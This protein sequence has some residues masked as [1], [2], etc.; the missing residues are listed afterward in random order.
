MPQEVPGK[1]WLVP[2]PIGNLGDM[3]L[4][5]LEI[6][7]LADAIA[8]EDTRHSGILLKHFKIEKPLV[9]LDAHTIPGRAKE[10][11]EK[12]SR[13]AY[14]SDAGSPGLSDPGAD[15]LRVALELG[16]AVEALP[17]ANALIPALS[18]SGLAMNQFAFYGFLPRSGGERQNILREIATSNKT[19]VLY[20]SPNRL[21]DTLQELI[22]YCGEI[23]KCAVARELSKLHEE[24]FRG[25]LASAQQHFKNVRGE[26]V[27]A[28]EANQNTGPVHDW[29]AQAL[30]LATQGQDARSIR[31]ALMKLGLERNRAYALALE[32]TSKQEK[33]E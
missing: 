2:T 20:E 22:L 9:R 7:R 25:S 31:A 28:I 18:V 14:I 6:L 30:H 1:L 11:L 19:C 17:G 29:Q 16:Y 23:R 12:H 10:V 8:C 5:G 24:I 32:A 33:Q 21:E 3:T 26:I 13:L 4:R 27:L 15:L